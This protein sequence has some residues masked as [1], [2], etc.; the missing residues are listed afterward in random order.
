MR[1]RT[2]MI[3]VVLAVILLLGCGTAATPPPRPGD[4]PTEGVG[5]PVGV[6]AVRELVTCL[7]GEQRALQPEA[8]GVLDTTQLLLGL[9]AKLDLQAPCF[10]GDSDVARIRRENDAAELVFGHPVDVAIAQR[11][12]E[13]DRDVIPTDERG[14]RVLRLEQALFVLGGEMAGHVL[15]RDDQGSWGCWAIQKGKQIDTAWI[16]VVRHAIEG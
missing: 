15:V 8:P 12:D 11:I 6:Q 2:I 9:L 10:L 16:E 4:T 1:S 13:K 3:T 7:G 5:L 14:Y